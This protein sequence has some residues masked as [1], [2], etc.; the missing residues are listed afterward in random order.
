MGWEL[1]IK[2]YNN[3]N[4]RQKDSDN[5][6]ATNLTFVSSK[7][8]NFA[9]EFICN[10]LEKWS[11][12]V[13]WSTCTDPCMGDSTRTRSRT[14]YMTAAAEEESEPCTNYCG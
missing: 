12:W 9:T 14:G 2:I 7:F 1:G 8:K 10:V 3:H 5:D 13:E 6:L 11:E 4:S